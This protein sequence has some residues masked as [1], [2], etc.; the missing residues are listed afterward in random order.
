MVPVIAWS[1]P[2]LPRGSLTLVKLMSFVNKPKPKPLYPRFTT[3]NKIL[4]IGRT[5]S[6]IPTE[7]KPRATA[8][9]ALDIPRCR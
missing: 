7:T 3:S 6:V 1:N 4:K 2:P 5:A 9:L 8:S